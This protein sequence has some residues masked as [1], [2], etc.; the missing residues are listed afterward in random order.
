MNLLTSLQTSFRNMEGVY[1]SLVL[2]AVS[3]SAQFYS[4]GSKT[5]MSYIEW[6]KTW[7]R[8]PLSKESFIL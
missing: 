1:I 4:V 6:N 7:I 8:H 5:A 2:H 3:L